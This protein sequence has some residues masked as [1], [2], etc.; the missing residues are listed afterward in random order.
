MNHTNME[1]NITATFNAQLHDTFYVGTAQISNNS[2][3]DLDNHR[4]H[5]Q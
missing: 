5:H 4:H 2:C 1:D 3:T